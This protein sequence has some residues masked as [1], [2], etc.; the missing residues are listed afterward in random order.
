MNDS[1]GHF[2]PS[3]QLLDLDVEAFRQAGID[4]FPNSWRDGDLLKQFGSDQ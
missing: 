4:V 3:D 2:Q 1:G